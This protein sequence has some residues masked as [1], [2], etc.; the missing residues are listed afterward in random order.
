MD[1]VHCMKGGEHT[2]TLH[3]VVYALG[4]TVS[5]IHILQDPHPE[6]I[7]ALQKEHSQIGTPAIPY[8]LKVP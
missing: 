1:S 3:I 2:P 7:K 4:Y 5:G 6:P 8:W